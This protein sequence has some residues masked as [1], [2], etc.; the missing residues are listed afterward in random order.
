VLHLI[1]DLHLD[2]LVCASFQLAFLQFHI[3]FISESAQVTP[4][5]FVFV[6]PD[7]CFGSR[8]VDVEDC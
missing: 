3:C 5:T 8:V 4:K 6:L 2:V 1:I 7:Q